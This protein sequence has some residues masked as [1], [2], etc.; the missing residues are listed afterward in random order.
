MT[1]IDIRKA[2]KDDIETIVANNRAMAK[3]TE[4]RALDE[5]MVLAGTRNLFNDPQ[6][7]FYLMA[8]Q[9]GRI[10]GQLMI[11]S[12]WS[13]WRNAD[14]WWI[15][16]VYVLPAARKQG[17]FRKLYQQLMSEVKSRDDI[18][19]LRLYTVKSNRNAQATYLALGMQKAKYEMFEV[20]LSLRP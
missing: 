16:S 9:N 7:G 4:D 1:A 11:T 8:E 14:I 10:V 20:D 19:G 17:V 2:V 5:A 18:C 3:E 13:D 15:Q 12:E 6:K